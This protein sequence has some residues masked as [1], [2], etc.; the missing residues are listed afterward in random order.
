MDF[1]ELSGLPPS[2]AAPE[3]PLALARDAAVREKLLQTCLRITAGRDREPGTAHCR[4]GA[5]DFR[6]QVPIQNASAHASSS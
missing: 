5:H 1:D 4:L 6:A 2:L 3:S